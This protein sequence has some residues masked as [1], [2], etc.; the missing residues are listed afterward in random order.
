L[1][2]STVFT[3]DTLF[4][5]SVGGVFGEKTGYQDILRSVTTKLF[6]LDE[7]TVV[8]PGHGPPSTIGLEKQHNPFFN[9]F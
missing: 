4:A 1:F 3:G 9:G 6:K 5:G 7:E 2:K 8:M